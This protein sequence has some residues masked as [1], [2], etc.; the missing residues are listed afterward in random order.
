MKNKTKFLYVVPSVMSAVMDINTSSITQ[1]QAKSVEEVD[2]SAIDNL[3]GDINDDGKI[4]ALDVVILQKWLSGKSSL[5]NWQNVD[6][7]ENGV[8][9]VYDLCLIKNKLINDENAQLYPV[10]DP[11]VIDVYV[12][13]EYI[14]DILDEYFDDWHFKVCC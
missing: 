10:E 6:L 9:N 4:N 3:L 14:E 2:I 8:I 12:S 5:T 13:F 1:F 11:V 7:D